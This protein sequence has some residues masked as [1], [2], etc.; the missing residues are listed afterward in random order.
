MRNR[1]V[2]SRISSP[3]DPIGCLSSNRDSSLTNVRKVCLD[4]GITVAAGGAACCLLTFLLRSTIHAIVAT[5]AHKSAITPITI[6]AIEPPDKDFDLLAFCVIASVRSGIATDVVAETAVVV[7]NVAGKV[8]DDVA[9]R[10]D[11]EVLDARLNP[12]RRPPED[13][14]SLRGIDC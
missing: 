14:Y 6:P 3:I 7:C 10:F 11:G 12:L 5:R 9:T 13:G 4:S 2:L 8:A 1:C